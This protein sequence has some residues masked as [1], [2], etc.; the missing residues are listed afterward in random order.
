M[1]YR[2]VDNRF[3]RNAGIDVV[4]SHYLEEL[5]NIMNDGSYIVGYPGFFYAPL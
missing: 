5:E 4:V 1:G 2:R 3:E